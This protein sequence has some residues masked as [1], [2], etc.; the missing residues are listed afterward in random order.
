M[1]THSIPFEVWTKDANKVIAT[2]RSYVRSIAK[3]QTDDV[4]SA[5]KAVALA[6]ELLVVLDAAPYGK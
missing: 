2:A 1:K 6:N 4:S 3:L 5:R